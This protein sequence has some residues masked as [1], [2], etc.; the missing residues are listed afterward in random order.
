MKLGILSLVFAGLALAAA[1]PVYINNAKQIELEKLPG[2]TRILAKKIIANRPYTKVDDL[3][4]A[5]VPKE[6]IEKI[7]PLVSAD[8]EMPVN[9]PPRQIVPKAQGKTKTKNAK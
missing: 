2:I 6:T 9:H 8:D 4:R 3:T 7:R 1:P 5:G